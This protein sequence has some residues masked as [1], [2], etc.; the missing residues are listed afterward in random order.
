M[1]WSEV[2]FSASLKDFLSDNLLT[3]FVTSIS[4]ILLE[5]ILLNIYTFL[6]LSRFSIWII[7]TS[8][9][10]IG[11]G[12]ATAYYIGKKWTPYLSVLY[13]ISI[14]VIFYYG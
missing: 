2:I 12:S 8:T 14:Y 6:T 13:S 9:V 3:I 11:L 10:G 1:K 5:L 7:A 4:L